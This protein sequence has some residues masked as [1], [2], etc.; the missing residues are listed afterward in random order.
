MDA[1]VV[2]LNSLILRE[3]NTA[4]PIRRKTITKKFREK[5]W[6]TGYLKNL[7]SKRQRQYYLFKQN[8]IALAQYKAF[9][10]SVNK[11]LRNSRNKL[12]KKL[13]TSVK[14]DIKETRN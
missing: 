3:Y 8:K 2:E 12:F 1:S 11:H 7:I 10:D 13:F 14:N 9:R 4:F 6:I 5:P